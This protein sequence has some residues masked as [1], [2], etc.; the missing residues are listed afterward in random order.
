MHHR[1]IYNHIN[2]VD[3]S[4]HTPSNIRIVPPDDLIKDWETDYISLSEHFLYAY[5]ERKD[6]NTLI[7][8]LFELQ[9]RFHSIK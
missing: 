4:K 2:S 9:S 3:Y 6:F 8:R 5:S 1:D 7:N